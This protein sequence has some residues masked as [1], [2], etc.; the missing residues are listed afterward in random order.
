[1]VSFETVLVVDDDPIVCAIT[2]AYFISIGATQVLEAGDGLQALKRF[3]QH[4]GEFD[5]ILCDLNMP[6]LD[7]LA[8]M[9]ELKELN[10]TGALAIISGEGSF[11]VETGEKL[12]VSH[13][14]S[15]IG[16]IRKPITKQALDE[17][18]SKVQMQQKPAS[19]HYAASITAEELALAIESDHVIPYYQPKIQVQDLK[20]VAVEALARWQDPDRGLIS[21][22]QFIPLS[23]ANGLIGA[24]S[25]SIIQRALSDAKRWH[26]HD[27]PVKV[28]VNISPDL[29]GDVSFPD[30]IAGWARHTGVD[31][32]RV[33]LEVTESGVLQSSDAVIEVLA[34]LKMQGFGISIDDFGTGTSNIDRLRK[35]PFSELKIDQAFIRE[36]SKDGFA[37][38]SVLASVLLGRELNMKLVAEG[39]ETLEEWDLVAN[40]GIDEVQGYLAAKPMPQ[41]EFESWYLENNGVAPLDL[42]DSKAIGA[43]VNGGAAARQQA[44]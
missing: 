23:E 18:C 44:N 43:G 2:A 38:A 14:L 21:P 13:G 30:T 17:L 8:F 6:E 4:K 31:I 33:V 20:I 3:D 39:V 11:V 16:T 42:S 32:E 40:C 15:F 34:R 5:L 37:R 28:S 1:M 35:L 19:Q 7:G 9:R 29:L 22:S 26:D 10:Y 12:A 41:A 24:L 25:S 27:I 36:A